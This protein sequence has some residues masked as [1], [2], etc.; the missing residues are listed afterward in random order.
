MLPPTTLPGC[1]FP[2]DAVFAQTKDYL[3]TVTNADLNR[4]LNEPQYSPLPTLSVPFCQRHQLQHL[5][6]RSDRIF[7]RPGQ[8]RR[9]VSWGRKAKGLTDRRSM[10]GTAADQFLI[11]QTARCGAGPLQR[12]VM[13]HRTARKPQPL[14]QQMPALESRFGWN[15]IGPIFCGHFSSR[16]EA[17][18]NPRLPRGC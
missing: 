15:G 12:L 3:E 4:V 14:S 16:R 1:L 8:I 17:N 7:V 18:S 11:Y 13:R 10:A 6:C 2:H 9:L 5:P